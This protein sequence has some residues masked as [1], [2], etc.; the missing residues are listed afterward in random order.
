MAINIKKKYKIFL[1][2]DT[3]LNLEI[4]S[5]NLT[6]KGIEKMEEQQ[7]IAICKDLK[8]NIE[9]VIINKNDHFDG[10]KT[11]KSGLQFSDDSVRSQY[12]ELINPSMHL[13]K[14]SSKLNE[15]NNPI[16]DPISHEVIDPKILSD[17]LIRYCELNRERTLYCYKHKISGLAYGFVSP[18]HKILYDLDMWKVVNN[19]VKDIPHSY[20]LRHHTFRME[21]NINFDE[22]AIEL[23]GN[24]SMKYRMCIGNSMF[25]QG[26]A[27]ITAGSFEQICT[28]GAKAWRTKVRKEWEEQWSELGITGGFDWRKAHI[29]SA[30]VILKDINKEITNQIGKADKYIGLLEEANEINESIFKENADI[31]AELQKKKFELTKKE[32]NEV[33]RLMKTRH[34]QYGRFNAF[35]TGRAIAE[36][37]RDTP[38]HQRAME[39]EQRAGYIMVTQVI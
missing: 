7:F 38:N 19:L 18:Q 29:I 28:N 2:Y 16:T 8:D 14:V 9:K 6:K 10:K 30:E 39:L 4:F 34:E 35:D 11:M 33:Y 23:A 26:S 17:K 22:I 5:R 13:A 27:F 15:L 21:I 1:K 3:I 36:V 24:N 12:I 20:D 25:G 32:A 31:V 37:A